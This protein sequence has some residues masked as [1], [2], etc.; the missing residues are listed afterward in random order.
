MYLFTYLLRIIIVYC[1]KKNYNN[2]NDFPRLSINYGNIN[3]YSI[4]IIVVN[5][6]F[7]YN[8]RDVL[9]I[10]FYFRKIYKKIEKQIKDIAKNFKNL[11]IIY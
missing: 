9:K 3:C 5:K 2:A 7:L 6:E 1:L 4:I 8:F 10:D 11:N